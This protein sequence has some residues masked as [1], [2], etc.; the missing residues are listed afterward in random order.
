MLIY[1]FTIVP[2]SLIIK[3]FNRDIIGLKFNK[4]KSY[5]KIIKE[6]KTNIN[7]QF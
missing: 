7:N 3:L 6:E 4:N 2:I 5:W 1:F